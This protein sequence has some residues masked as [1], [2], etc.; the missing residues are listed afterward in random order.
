MLAELQFTFSF[1]ELRKEKQHYLLILFLKVALH[2][3]TSGQKF[4]VFRRPQEKHN[5]QSAKTEFF[6][7]DNKDEQTYRHLFIVKHIDCVLCVM[8]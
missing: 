8:W 1:I 4:L 3:H 2:L 5:N 6:H 7:R